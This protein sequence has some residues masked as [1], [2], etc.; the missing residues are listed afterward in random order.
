MRMIAALLSTAALTLGLGASA[1]AAPQGMAPYPGE[2]GSNAAPP[3]PPNVAGPGAVQ[4]P[5]QKRKP[6]C[7]WRRN[8]SGWQPV[9]DYT[10]IVR[11]G[12]K[13]YLVTFDGRCR[14][15]RDQFGMQIT[16]GYGSCLGEGDVVNFTSSPFG[17]GYRNAL[18]D[19]CMIR[20]IEIAPDK[21][22]QR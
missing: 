18:H 4:P 10:M 16:R 8:I 20:K 2:V 11:Q 3:P 22:A 19:S 21:T 17:H 15:Q 14:G 5:A 12:S 6:G 7:V 9:D 1:L 13:R